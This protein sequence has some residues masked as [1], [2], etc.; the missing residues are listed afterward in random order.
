MPSLDYLIIGLFGAIIFSVGFAFAKSGSNV[1]SFFAAGGSLPWWL[2]GL[3]LF[4]SFFSA[5]TFVVWGSIAYELGWVA[6]TIQWMMGI[7]GLLIGLFI[8]GR[9]RKTGVLTVAEYVGQRFGARLKKFYSY[10]FLLLSFVT[11][12]A[13]LYPVAKIFNVSTG[14][15][16]E[17]SIIGLGLLVIAYT[18]AGGLW[19][20]VITDV[21]QFV[22]LFAA[23]LIVVPL[24]LHEVGGFGN[25]LEEVP[26]GFFNLVSEEYSGWFLAAFLFYNTIF[27]GGNWAYVQRYTSVASPADAKKAAW[28]FAALYTIS[29]VLWM[30][31]P[32]IYRVLNPELVDLENEGAF[33]L[34]CK[35]VLPTGLLGLMLAGMIFATASSVNTTLNMMAAV[36]TNDVYSRFFGSDSRLSTMAV[37]KLSTI[38]FGLVSIVVALLVP[39]AGGIVDFVIS[40][41][42]ITGAPLFAPTIWALFSTRQ[43]TQSV[44]IVTIGSLLINIVLKFIAPSAFGISLDTAQEM[45]V[46]VF[47]PLILLAFFEIFPVGVKRAYSAPQPS[48]DFTPDQTENG[49]ALKILSLALMLIGIL[50]FVLGFGG[51]VG[52]FW[53]LSIGISVVLIGVG[54]YRWAAKLQS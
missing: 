22:I 1:K 3:S 40:V 14:F 13:F 5:G 8:A 45:M 25:F 19:A 53:I 7:S 44:L 28:L 36:F 27:I 16:I 49:Y 35:S 39:A 12:G 30:L 21:L 37:A 31:P 38:F 2:S 26:D 34:I 20:V 46:G 42:A 10:I 23:V 32:M 29:P 6:I 52:K 24:A 47:V 51:E 54:I 50:I 4:M 15:S 9:W 17:A 11:T 48:D 18:A 33:L 41:G 43:T